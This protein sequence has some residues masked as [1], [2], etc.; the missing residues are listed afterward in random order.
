LFASPKQVLWQSGLR[1]IFDPKIEPN[2]N[3]KTLI[4]KNQKN[5]NFTFGE[6]EEE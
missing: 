3:E 1:K 4:Q 2:K 5:K 6:V